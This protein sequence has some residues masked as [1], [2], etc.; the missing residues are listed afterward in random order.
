[1]DTTGSLRRDMR[2]L[3]GL[4]DASP[5]GNKFTMP[6]F[7]DGSS[8]EPGDPIYETIAS[9]FDPEV[10]NSLD[11]DTQWS[12]IESLEA[13][14]PAAKPLDRAPASP[15]LKAMD[16]AHK[17]R[18]PFGPSDIGGLFGSDRTRGR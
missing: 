18:L 12:V 14:K 15:S 4:P 17:A 3:G 7:E 16:T 11:E 9:H 8:Y 10:W 1:M 5:P 13:A 6:F 2:S